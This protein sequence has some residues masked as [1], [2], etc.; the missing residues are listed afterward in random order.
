MGILSFYNMPKPR[1]YDHQPIYYDP[2]KEALKKRIQ[3]VKQELGVEETNYEDYKES[4][5]GS[6]TEGTS[7][8]KRS[9][10]R[11]DGLSDRERKNMRLLLV[12]AVLI[13]LLFF[14]F[15]K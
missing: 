13:F 5:R 1:Q 11:G 10:E 6:F 9:K 3:K 12:L 4:I 7:H 8:L 15:L 2:K 14:F